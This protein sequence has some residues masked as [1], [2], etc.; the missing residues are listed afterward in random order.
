MPGEKLK[1]LLIVSLAVL[2]VTVVGCAPE[3]YEVEIQAD[4]EEAGEIE[5]EGT[6]EEGE[7]VVV[8]AEPEEG[9]EFEKW[10]KDDVKV[11][12]QE[13]YEFEVPEDKLLE[14]LFVEQA[15]EQD[16]PDQ[17]LPEELEQLLLE[18]E[19]DKI[20][21]GILNLREILEQEGD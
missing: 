13:K 18:G 6:Y 3:E 14:G 4:P 17:D 2:L 20:D 16:L 7:E 15:V 11:S 21:G 5:G 12:S 1:Y 8:E 10:E 9:Y 19:E